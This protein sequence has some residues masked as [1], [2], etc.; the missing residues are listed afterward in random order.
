MLIIRR[1]KLFYTASGITTPVGSH[2]VHR[3]REEAEVF[4]V[5]NKF[6]EDGSMLPKHVGFVG[7]MNRNL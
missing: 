3:C 2:P 7:N 5:V 4:F 1:S 6:P